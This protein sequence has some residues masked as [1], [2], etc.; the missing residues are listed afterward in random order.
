M[1]DALYIHPEWHRLAE[2]R[3]QAL[4]KRMAVASL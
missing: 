3:E 4:A 2:D 1:S